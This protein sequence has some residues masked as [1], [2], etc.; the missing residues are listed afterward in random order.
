MY[1]PLGDCSLFDSSS[2]LHAKSRTFH[3]EPEF[4]SICFERFVLWARFVLYSFSLLK[5]RNGMLFRRTKLP[6]LES[7]KKTCAINSKST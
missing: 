5:R 1:L 3:L 4:L 7:I 2:F 6:S